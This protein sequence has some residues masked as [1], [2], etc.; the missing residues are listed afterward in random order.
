MPEEADIVIRYLARNFGPGS[1]PMQTGTLPPD[2]A[3]GSGSVPEAGDAVSL[4]SGDG[5]DL[6]ESRC[7]V[8]H[9]LGRVV[10]A[11]RSR[12]EWERITKNMM[13]RGPTA[14]PEQIQTMVFYLTAQFGK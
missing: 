14:T 12:A 13:G 11:R 4:P 2:T 7:R 6:V 10:T 8:C 1:N 3:L 9:D 5:K